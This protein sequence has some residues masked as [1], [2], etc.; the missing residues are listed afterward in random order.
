MRLTNAISHRAPKGWLGF[1]DDEL[2]P[3]DVA[4]Q[5]KKLDTL[6]RDQRRAIEGEETIPTINGAMRTWLTQQFPIDDGRGNL[7]IGGISIDITERERAEQL[8]K[9][10]QRAMNATSEGIVVCD[11]SKPDLPI[12]Y[13]KLAFQKI[14]RYAPSEVVGRNC[15]FLQGPETNPTTVA[16]IRDA[17]KEGRSTAVELLNYR[18]DGSTFWNLLSITPVRDAN[19]QITHFVGVQRDITERRLIAEQMRQAQKMEAI[20]RLAGGIAHDFNNL[21]TIV[22]GNAELAMEDTPPSDSRRELIQEIAHAGQRAASLTTQLLAFS[23]KQVMEPRVVDLNV[24]VVRY[25]TIAA[26]FDR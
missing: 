5:C 8:L 26:P 24:L 15:R 10:Q 4:T 22:L 2:F 16:E 3:P 19:D 25:G 23:R 12:V 9:L 7:L 18:R 11:A 17:I 21:L 1:T 6:V 13:V 14:T 20:G